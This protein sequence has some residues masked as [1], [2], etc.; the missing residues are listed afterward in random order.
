M[1]DFSQFFNLLKGYML[2]VPVSLHCEYP[3][4][5][6]ESGASKLTIK[7]EDVIS[8]IRKDL[9]L[10]KQYLQEAGLV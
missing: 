4:G 10:L 3:L 5:G 7:E 6:A 2:K 9:T 8:A 1:V